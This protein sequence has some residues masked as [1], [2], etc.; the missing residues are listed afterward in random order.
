MTALLLAAALSLEVL[1]AESD[2]SGF[3]DLPDSLWAIPGTAF[4]VI[5]EDTVGAEPS[6]SGARS[7]LLVEDAIEAGDSVLLCFERS[8][9]AVANSARLE[10]PVLGREAAA[11]MLTPPPEATPQGL[12][13]SGSKKLG[14]AVGDGPGVDQSTRL[15][16]SGSLAPGI[17]VEGSI[18]DENLPLGTGSSE[19][20]S[21]LDKVVLDISGRRWGVTLGDQ[22]W[23][24]EGTGALPYRRD[25]TGVDAGF[26]SLSH[27]SASA[28]AGV[29]GQTADR[30]VFTT[31]EGVQGP[32][33]LTD[34]DEIVPGSER[35]WLDGTLMRRGPS[36]DYTMDYPAGMVTFTAGRLIRR[37][38]RV[39]ATFYRRGAGYRRDLYRASAATEYEGFSL[40]L[41]GLSEA[42]NRGHPLG[43]ILSDEALEALRSAGEEPDSVWIDGA[44]WVGPGEGSYSL[45]GEGHYQYEGPGQGEWRVVFSRPPGEPGDYIYDSVIGGFLWVGVGEGTHLPREYLDIPAGGSVGG[46]VASALAGDL[47]LSLETAVST[48]TGNTFNSEGTTR[49]GSAFRGVSGWRPFGGEL[50]IGISTVLVTDGFRQPGVW[51]SDSSL[52]SWSLPSSWEGRDDIVEAFVQWQGGAA[53][54]GARLLAGGGRVLLARAGSRFEAGRF[55]VVTHA[56]SAGREDAASLPSGSAVDGGADLAVS[57]GAFV[58]T[59]GLSW[60]RDSWGDSLSGSRLTAR[61]GSAFSVARWTSALSL[62][63]VFDER[64]GPAPV[65]R[66]TYRCRGEAA[67]GEPGWS[68]SASI[69]HSSSFWDG[70]GRM[71]ADALRLNGS[72]GGGGT[73]LTLAYSGSG[74]LSQALEVHYRFVGEGQGGWSYDD[75]TGEFYEDP[76]GSYEVYYLPGEGGDLQLEAEAELSLTSGAALGPGFDGSLELTSR[77]SDDRLATLLL[78]KSFGDAPGGY[79]A[80]LSPFWRGA[81]TV[82]LLRARGKVTEQRIEYSGSGVRSES[83]RM[84]ELQQGLSPAG[85]L[86]LDLLQR[87]RLREEDL[88]ASRRITETRVSADPSITL[89]SGLEPGI[90][91]AY[92][93]RRES[94]S[95]L[96]AGQYE[97]RPHLRFARS[98]W[99]AWGSAQGQYIP[100][101]G[102]LPLWLFDGNSTGLNLLFQLRIGRNISEQ[103]DAAL[104]WYAR[105][106]ADGDWTQRAGLEGTVTF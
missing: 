39:E 38:S 17:E 78:A 43:F 82:R 1:P 101:D 44:T 79:S 28:G 30:A 84:I 56:S 23:E 58:P 92:E 47:D 71:E 15:S 32:Y 87:Y 2:G 69:E 100:G 102:D 14:I 72:T 51:E 8:S 4:V 89:D 27:Y 63:A 11:P 104:T 48:R 95:G 9:L 97:A 75:E 52:G 90:Q 12:F 10:T 76:D 18:T 40:E 45:D 25:L 49:E 46:A 41:T 66:R 85:S 99:N 19:L 31:G 103:L 22:E 35:I 62:E 105:R 73:W 54:T 16:L 61:T 57:I 21:E 93:N 13:I 50:R 6:A 65:P 24:R 42:D 67:G 70:G 20:V 55:Q 106:P 80:E 53:S 64:V 33:S 86:D 88:Q 7:G 91:F 83:E 37:D 98:G 29:S 96:E 60:L 5:G 59:I 74:T 81:G 36:A 68:L 34:G 3:F 94:H 77:G 26:D